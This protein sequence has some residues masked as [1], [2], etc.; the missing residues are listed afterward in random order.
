VP[1]R[2]LLTAALLLLT[3]VALR[4]ADA[5]ARPKPRGAFAHDCAVGAVA[6]APDGVYLVTGADDGVIRV[7]ERATGAEVRQLTGH[8]GRVSALSFSPDGRTLA[9]GSG[10]QTVGVWDFDSGKLLHRCEGHDG[11]ARSVQ[12]GPDGKTIASGSHDGTVR[13]WDARTGKELRRFEEHEAPVAAVSFMPDGKRLVSCDHDNVSRL[14]DVT[15]GKQVLVL[16][17]QKRGALTGVVVCGGGRLVV[18]GS[19]HGY[20]SLWNPESGE[21]LDRLSAN[22]A[23]LSLTAS[24]DGRLFVAGTV[25]GEIR[26]YE[27]ASRQHLLT[28]HGYE[29]NWDPV[30]FFPTSGVPTAIHALAFSPDGAWIAAGTKDGEVR[31]WRFA[32]LV[33]G[34]QAAE[35]LRPED[36]DGVWSELASAEGLAGCRALVRLASAPDLALPYLRPRLTPTPRIDAARVRKL[37]A[38]LDDDDFAVRERASE[39]LGRYSELVSPQLRQALRDGKLSAEAAN[40]VRLLLQRVDGSE[41]SPERL[42]ES[43]AVQALE[44]MATREARAHLAELAK[45]EPGGALTEEAMQALARLGRRAR[46]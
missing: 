25:E 28:F 15:T 36:L 4:A 9:S 39:Q 46:P 44:W 43:R 10:D 20:L 24:A 21:L 32:D 34:D 3:P 29:G 22:A 19:A 18:T 8:R 35:K 12:F 13:L 26:L 45:G 38:E 14:W 23:V 40:R 6:F 11:W 1:I 16:P 30:N 27:A 33:R 37:V 17:K 2:P 5:P 31:L 7:W 42:R 41:P